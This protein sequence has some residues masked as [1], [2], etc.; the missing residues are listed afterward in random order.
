MKRNLLLIAAL[1]AGLSVSA[2]TTYNYFDPADC[3]ADGWLWFN[4][5]AKLEKYCGFKSD[6]NFKILLEPSTWL[7]E[8]FSNDEPYLDGEIEGYNAEG[9]EGGPGSWTGAIVLSNATTRIGTDSPDG[10]GILFQLP[11]CA[12][13][14]V[15]LSCENGFI[16]LGL[17]GAKGENVQPIDLAKIYS[18]MKM[19]WGTL[20]PLSS[21]AQYTWTN[22]QDVAN[23]QTLFCLKSTEPVTGMIRNNTNAP[24]LVQGIRIF[25]YT[26]TNNGS[27]VADMNVDDASAPVR[28]YNMQGVEVS[29]SEPGIYI[30]RQ[31]SKVSKIAL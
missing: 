15:A 20:K 5:D 26:D 11:D 2:Q 18:C 12:Q 28:F 1:A 30:R 17:Y 13:I 8:S 27:G 24:L 7:N 29:G 23:G 22:V 16:I 3:D 19:T 21:Q 9:V 31:G 10:G 4:S 14:D 25:T 6:G